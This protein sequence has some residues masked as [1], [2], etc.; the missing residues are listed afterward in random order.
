MQSYFDN[1][2]GDVTLAVKISFEIKVPT[3]SL[4]KKRTFFDQSFFLVKNIFIEFCF[5]MIFYD[6]NKILS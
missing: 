2:N 1:T 3:S 6:D 5:K 4:G